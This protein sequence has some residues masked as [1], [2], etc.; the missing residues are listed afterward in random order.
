MMP[1]RAGPA[2]LL[3]CQFA[4]AV[5]GWRQ[6]RLFQSRSGGDL[7]SVLTA[8]G[9][10]APLAALNDKARAAVARLISDPATLGTP[11]ENRQGW[12]PSPKPGSILIPVSAPDCQSEPAVA[13]PTSLGPSKSSTT[14]ID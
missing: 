10:E 9:F 13:A 1:A 2:R 5:C 8:A 14:L 6:H 7:E 12:L 11:T 3:S 4:Q